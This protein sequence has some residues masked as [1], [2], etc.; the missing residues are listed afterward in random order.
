MSG[1]VLTKGLQNLR[2]QVDRAF[3]ARDK[4]S[5]GTIG[6][7]AH[8][9]ETSGHNPDDTPGSRPEWDG[10]SDSTPEVRAWDMD[11]DLR[12]P[13]VTAQDVVDHLRQLPGLST[14]LRYM[15]YDRLIYEASTG[16]QPRP[17]TGASAHT[18]H[19]HFSGARSQAADED[20]TFDYRL[21]ELGQGDDDM[22]IREGDTGEQ[23]RFWQTCLADLGYQVGDVDGSYGPHLA[24]AIAKFRTDHG[25]TAQFTYTTGWTGWL[26]LRE[27]AK[28]YAGK[29]T[30]GPA[31]PPGAAGAKGDR[32]PAGPAG[33]LTGALAVTGGQ[34]Q[35]TTTPAA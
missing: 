28:K 19:I 14:V 29:G 7:T 33:T 34:L 23:V 18:E 2:E 1:W 27:V 15:I 25:A 12:R 35:V 5:D 8:Q 9:A 4:T 16:W 10:D 21:G 22:M 26:L 13:G 17:Y 11:S 3:P 31:G 32:G 20:T 30:P 6:D 24:A